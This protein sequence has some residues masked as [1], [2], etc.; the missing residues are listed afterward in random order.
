MF[1]EKPKAMP[2]PKTVQVTE[3]NKLDYSQQREDNS[4]LSVDR[5]YSQVSGHR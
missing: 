2:L 3:R 5:S 4:K 1:E